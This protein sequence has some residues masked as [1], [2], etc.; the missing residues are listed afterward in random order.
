MD[1]I[2]ALLRMRGELACLVSEDGVAH[3]VC[4]GVDIMDFAAAELVGVDFLEGRRFGFGRVDVLACLVEV[5]LG[6]F[7]RV[8][9]ILLDILGSEEWPAD[10][11]DL[12]GQP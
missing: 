4:C 11:V 10:K 12:L 8:W 5:T 9:V 2:V 3:L 6:C 1:V 7:G